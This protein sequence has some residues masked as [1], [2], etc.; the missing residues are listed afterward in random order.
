MAAVANNSK[1]AK[2]T[3]IPQSVGRDYVKAD[4]G[5][6][7]R[8][9][10]LMANCVTEKKMKM[11]G[12][13]GTHKMPDGTTMRDSEHK[14]AMSKM[15]GA[16][17]R[18][19]AQ[20]EMG[21]MGGGMVPEYREGGKLEMVEQNGKMVPAYAADGKGKMF[22]GGGVKSKATSKVRGYGKARGGRPC[23]MV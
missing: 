14:V 10:G 12:M 6:T 9:G 4:K 5:R 19:M 21:M 13:T 23:K 1:F 8:A 17:R 15:G 3:G 16:T 7:F 20:E 22:H 18:T 2:K 11:G